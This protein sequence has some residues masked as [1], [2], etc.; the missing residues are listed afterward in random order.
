[1]F[2]LEHIK[3][4]ELVAKKAAEVRGNAEALEKLVIKSEDET[5]QLDDETLR[6]KFAEISAYLAGK[7]KSCCIKL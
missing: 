1:M 7:I 4:K 2:G 6:K 3:D 5:I